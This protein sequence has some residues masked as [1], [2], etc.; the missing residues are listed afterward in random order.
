MYIYE[1][2][3][4]YTSN[5]YAFIT[6]KVFQIFFYRKLIVNRKNKNIDFALVK[7]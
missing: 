1:N 2:F 5:I 3:T 4:K 6:Y 7:S